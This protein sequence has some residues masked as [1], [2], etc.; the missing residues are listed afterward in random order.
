MTLAASIQWDLLPPL[1][2]TS[3]SLNAAGMLE[4]AYDV[5]GDSFDYALNDSFFQMAIVDAA[6]HGIAAAMIS[7]LAVG[8]YRHDRR[9]GHGIDRIHSNLDA[10]LETHQPRAAFATGQLAHVDLLTGAMSWT[11]AGHPPPLLVRGGRVERE[12]QCPPTPPWG[13]GHL[14]TDRAV[15]IGTEQLVPGD[16][17]LFYTDG[18]VESR[19]P[20]G[21]FFGLDRLARLVA[22][23]SG[24][25]ARPEETAR[26]VVQSV[27]DH[28]GDPL[29]DDATLVLW[30]WDGPLA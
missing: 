21:E 17:V 6:G 29:R 13:F 18:V 25:A 15:P 11:N 19:D 27:I 22:E 20:G 26:R 10:V 16:Q 7:V 2:L 12:L 8:S 5:G 4:P 23:H 14:A 3:R 1:T 9:E 30:Q 28:S 24:V